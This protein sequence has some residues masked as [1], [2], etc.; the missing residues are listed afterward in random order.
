MLALLLFNSEY[1]MLK[2]N[3]VCKSMGGVAAGMLFSTLFI[4]RT[5]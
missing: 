2:V 3:N 5:R 4:I 1:F